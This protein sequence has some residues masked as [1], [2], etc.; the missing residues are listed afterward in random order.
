MVLKFLE[1]NLLTLILACELNRHLN[2]AAI[3]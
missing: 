3:M 1:P 2:S